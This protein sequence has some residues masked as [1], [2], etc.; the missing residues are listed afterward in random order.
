MLCGLKFGLS[1][2]GALVAAILAAYGYDAALPAQAPDVVHGIKLAV[3]VYC[4]IP[5]LLGVALLFGYEVDKSME[6]RIEREL[7]ARRARAVTPA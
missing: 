4:S 1:I 7:G 5:F 3:S 2:G 6:T